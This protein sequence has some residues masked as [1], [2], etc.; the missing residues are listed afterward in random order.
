M[1]RRID[2]AGSGYF[3][4]DSLEK[5]ITQRGKDQDTLQDVIDALTVFD[6]DRDGKIPVQDFAKAMITMGEK[7]SE[8]EI[9]EIVEDAELINGEYIEVATFARLIMDRI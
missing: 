2:P 8:E 5:L 3:D 4:L 6:N 1:K 7:M 9:K